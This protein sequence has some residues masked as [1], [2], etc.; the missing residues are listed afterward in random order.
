MGSALR[1]AAEVAGK[2][3][4]TRP[5]GAFEALLEEKRPSSIGMHMSRG[6]AA[7]P[8]PAPER[9]QPVAAAPPALPMEPPPVSTPAF[10]E[11]EPLKIVEKPASS[12]SDHDVAPPTFF[13]GA[14]DPDEEDGGGKTKAI[15]ILAAV[16]LL[17]SS[18]G[19]LS[20]K[21]T[22]SK[23]AT[24]AASTAAA[25][26]PA[27]TTPETTAPVNDR[28]K[29]QETTAPTPDVS[30]I[31]IG[32]DS[33]TATAPVAK[34]AASK[35]VV[36]EAGPADTDPEPEV[37]QR[38]IVKNDTRRVTLPPTPPD[39][40]VQAPSVDMGA[41]PDTKALA[42]IGNTP[43]RVPKAAP[44]VVRVSQGVMEGLVI[45]RVQPKYPSQAMQLHIQGSVQLQATVSK[46]GSIANLKVVSGDGLLAR[47]AQ[48][49][50]KQWQYKPY[51][52]NGEPV[53]IQTQILVNFKLPN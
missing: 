38:I 28:T 29:T 52:L 9:M 26:A 3:E 43:A 11:P 53:E 50:V 10:A 14:Y 33:G 31:T 16:V 8:A 6:T 2:V 39:E 18:A 7:A 51:Y 36:K 17:A 45:K 24:A 44:Q 21:D 4:P 25:T 32:G 19:Y 37:T 49:A 20:W 12:H 40:P 47:A 5:V 15:V 27:A 35:P 41:V 23:N 46:D 13:P 34:P 48:E 22:H 1:R 30:E 42:S